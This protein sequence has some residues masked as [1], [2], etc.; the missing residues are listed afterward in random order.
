MEGER[1]VAVV[2]GIEGPEDD[3][4]E[5]LS[6]A[7]PQLKAASRQSARLAAVLREFRYSGELPS[8]VPDSQD[9]KAFFTKAFSDDDLQLVHVAAHG[10]LGN[11]AHDL[12][13]VGPD[14]QKSDMKVAHLLESAR[15]GRRPVLLLLDLCHSGHAVEMQLSNPAIGGVK[16]ERAWVITATGG[17]LAYDCRLT[18][19]VA[20]VLEGYRSKRL[21]VDPSVSHIPWQHFAQAVGAAVDAMAQAGFPQEVESTYLP[22]HMQPLLLPFFPNPRYDPALPSP[23]EQD[24]DLDPLLDPAHFLTRVRAAPPDE[25]QHSTFFKGRT[26][27]LERI[28]G[29]L[30]GKGPPTL[31][32]TG[33][34]GAGKSALIG[35]V[36]CRI[37]PKL[38]DNAQVRTL[39]DEPLLPRPAVGGL[40]VIHARRRTVAEVCASLARQWQ[41][42]DREPGTG[43]TG[44]LL[45]ERLRDRAAGNGS[46]PL[47]LVVDAVDEANDPS[48]LVTEVLEPIFA[49]TLPDGAPLCRT[50][51]GLRRGPGPDDFFRLDEAREILDLGDVRGS[52]LESAVREYVAALLAR[53]RYGEIVNDGACR[54]LSKSVAA[55]LTADD[56]ATGP[57]E[58]GEFLV[59]GLYAQH[60]LRGPPV[61]EDEA[62]DLGAR[63]PRTLA[64]LLRLEFGKAWVKR[65]TFA[66]ATA[67]AYAEGSGMP[68]DIILTVAGVVSAIVA[69][70]HGPPPTA[71]DVRQGLQDLKFYLRQDVDTNA[72]TLYRLFHQS[73]ADELRHQLEQRAGTAVDGWTP[74]EDETAV[75]S[76]AER[77]IWAAILEKVSATA[78]RWKNVSP[79]LWRNAPRHAVAA[80]GLEELLHD[81]DFLMYADP[82]SLMAELA[83]R[84][85]TFA[86]R[87]VAA[88]RA[89][90][91]R[92]RDMTPRLRGDVLAI[93]ACRF[94]IPRLAAALTRTRPWQV[95]WG[96]NGARSVYLRHT[97]RLGA[98]VVLL[99][100]TGTDSR[101]EVV[102]LGEDGTICV[103]GLASGREVNRQRISGP[104]VGS[105]VQA[106]GELQGRA[107]V[108]SAGDD[109]VVRVRE[110]A[111]GRIVGHEMDCRPDRVASVALGSIGEGAVVVV[112]SAGGGIRVWDPVAGR[113]VSELRRTGRSVSSV[114]VLD[115][116]GLPRAIS[117][118][119]DGGVEMWDLLTDEAVSR[120]SWNQGAGIRAL[121]VL[122]D[123]EHPLLVSGGSDGSVRVW[124]LSAPN[125]S[126]PPLTSGSHPI[127]ALVPGRPTGRAVALSGSADGILRVWDLDAHE[128]AGPAI[129]GHSSPVS[130][131]ALGQVDDEALAVSG[132]AD[133]TVRVWNMVDA[134]G[135]DRPVDEPAGDRS[136]EFSTQEQAP[137]ARGHSG[138]VSAL[139]VGADDASSTAVSGSANGTVRVWDLSTGH[140]ISVSQSDHVGR[141][142]SVACGRTQDRAICVSAGQD[143][144]VRLWDR[145]SGASIGEPLRDVGGPVYAVAI[146]QLDGELFAVFGG[147]GDSVWMM[148]LPAGPPEPLAP[149]VGVVRALATGTVE[150][151]PV[152]VVALADAL[153]VYDLADRT[154]TGD[155]M[156]SGEG[157]VSCLAVGSAQGRPIAVAGH[158]NGAIVFWDLTTRTRFAVDRDARERAVLAVAIGILNGNIVA[159]GGFDDHDQPGSVLRTWDA[160][161]GAPLDEQGTPDAVRAAAVTPDGTLVIGQRN[162]VV[163]LVPAPPAR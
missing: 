120:D 93:D 85:G 39:S 108:V 161:T 31:I 162:D 105:G 68:E 91:E 74:Q 72:E 14:G 133:G 78:G 65:P 18:T 142:W 159:V 66:V 98:P 129:S 134:E 80:G 75:P 53:S 63:V 99:A 104:G 50:L 154:R 42:R 110:L 149:S 9:M 70:D 114:A 101:A 150:R 56:A 89:S 106:V 109:Q 115:V 138:V 36:V 121:C 86:G 157:A 81:P 116:D 163:V 8:P 67:L 156:V 117:G 97:L 47:Y 12:W 21:T 15:D 141:I 28:A 49:L 83:H 2:L 46:R 76:R 145:T 54:V 44:R 155:T 17:D 144:T 55:A 41:F 118:S 96:T 84:P 11:Y 45:V 88:Y 1:R 146:A 82:A 94:D 6:P 131:V 35:V 79:Y 19:A 64:D 27:E 24:P 13:I 40:A 48:A 90:A 139:A 127:T 160:A 132:S 123:A 16:N 147:R 119:V 124:D 23:E 52:R 111:T 59:A 4:R 135:D 34:P 130:C 107:V 3:G 95:R 20:D 7:L 69:G 26:E 30:R 32:V 92:H 136:A 112:G 140:S 128:Q 29:W 103:W 113:L 152:V 137:A 38:R 143:G 102:A 33:K 25:A 77:L 57:L 62:G 73:L 122:E 153:V 61:S 37:H 100:V 43:W 87:A 22:S 60:L 125:P 158:T 58:W 126:R 10:R 148:E 151:R 51:V 71:E 5:R